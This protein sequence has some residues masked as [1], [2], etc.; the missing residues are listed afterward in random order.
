MKITE[1]RL[2]KSSKNTEILISVFVIPIKLY[3]QC[4]E[5]RIIVSESKYERY[6]SDSNDHNKNQ[7]NRIRVILTVLSSELRLNTVSF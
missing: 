1:V 4:T 7:N 2:Q 6:E 5:F 3:C